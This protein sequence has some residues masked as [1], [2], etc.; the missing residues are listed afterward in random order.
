MTKEYHRV[1]RRRWADFVFSSFAA[2]LPIS[3][4]LH[5]ACYGGK[6]K[7]GGRVARRE[8]LHSRGLSSQLPGTGRYLVEVGGRSNCGCHGCGYESV[9]LLIHKEAK[10]R[11][12]SEV[13]T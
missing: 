6:R 7:Y 10:A 5:G 13:V 9:L 1:R 3:D 2:S 8:G 12:T 11:W 4:Q